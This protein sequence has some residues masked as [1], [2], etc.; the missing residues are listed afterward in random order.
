LGIILLRISSVLDNKDLF[1][2]VN[3]LSFAAVWGCQ[4]LAKVQ[5]QTF[6][7][8]IEVAQY[9]GIAGFSAIAL[10]AAFRLVFQLLYSLI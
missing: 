1:V 3:L 8:W 5:F 4:M 7:S 6:P 2:F 9:C 10:M